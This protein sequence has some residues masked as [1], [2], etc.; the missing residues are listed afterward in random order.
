MT[1]RERNLA[2]CFCFGRTLADFKVW[3]WMGGREP[4]THIPPR[5][6]AWLSTL[7][8][9]LLT[10]EGSPSLKQAFTLPFW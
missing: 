10:I 3:Q 2:G 5:H 4:E 9:G 8:S 6:F 1:A 7:V